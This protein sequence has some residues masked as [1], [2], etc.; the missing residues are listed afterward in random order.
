MHITRLQLS[1]FRS[2]AELG[3]D[4]G[5]GITLVSG[6][7]AAGKSNLVEAIYMLAS[8]RSTR[9][10]TEGELIRW[11]AEEPQVM[12]VA[13]TALA[14]SEPVEVE[15]ALAARVGGAAGAAG[16]G[17]Q[18]SG[19]PLTSKRIRVNG[20]NRRAAEALG[21]IRA[22][23][24]TTLD[25]DLL[26]GSSSVRRRYLD[27]AIGQLDRSHASNLSRYQRTLSQRNALLKLIAEGRAYESE[28]Q[29]WDEML[30]S[31]A[32]QIWSARAEAGQTLSDLAAARHVGLRAPDDPAESLSLTYQP[33]DSQTLRESR[34]RDLA[35]GSTSVGPHRDDLLIDLDG[36]PAANFASR[37]Q[38]RAAALSMR[39]AEADYL[40]AQSADSP[41]LLLD[42]VFSELDPARRE[43]TAEA[44]AA[45]EQV[46]LTTA[47]PAVIPF[48]P[49]E[50]AASYVIADAELRLDRGS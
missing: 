33:A 4:L 24:F 8:L 42:D 48:Q 10:Q 38:Q 47:D 11:E 50:L 40:A 25:L 45:V 6:A 27:V 41:I 34:P 23:Q 30:E 26:T 3:L 21:A 22:V 32:E 16:A 2:W 12:R 44:V 7:N 9:A 37:A 39:L 5:P 17:R 28:L 49:T 46:I 35:R 43:R 18:R 36:R 29:Q 13:A 19:A 14:D 1:N 20:V 15:I 31:S